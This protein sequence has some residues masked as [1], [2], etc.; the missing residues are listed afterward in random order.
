MILSLEPSVDF[1]QC[2]TCREKEERTGTGVERC[3]TCVETFVGGAPVLAETDQRVDCQRDLELALVSAPP[4]P[5]RARIPPPLPKQS[6]AALQQPRRLPSPRQLR[7]RHAHDDTEEEQAEKKEGQSTDNG[8][9]SAATTTIA[10]ATDD[11]PH[12]LS[13]RKLRTAQQ[14]RSTHAAAN[15]NH[16]SHTG[17]EIRTATGLSLCSSNHADAYL[18]AARRRPR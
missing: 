12:A 9:G 4:S 3:N 10:A 2:K 18:T 16:C 17:A 15:E 1:P 11:A 8:K 6:L 14:P 7:S 5:S 13:A